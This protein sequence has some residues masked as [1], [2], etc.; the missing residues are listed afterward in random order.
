VFDF[1]AIGCFLTVLEKNQVYKKP[2]ASNKA[3]PSFRFILLGGW[4]LTHTKKNIRGPN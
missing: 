4:F 2:H 1:I 3:K